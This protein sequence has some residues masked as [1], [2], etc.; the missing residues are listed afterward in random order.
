MQEGGGGAG[1]EQEGAG[2]W[3]A[4]FVKAINGGTHIDQNNSACYF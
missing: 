4:D 2:G 3:R 1:G